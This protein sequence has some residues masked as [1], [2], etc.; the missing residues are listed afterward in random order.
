MNVSERSCSESAFWERHTAKKRFALHHWICLIL[1]LQLQLFRISYALEFVSHHP[2]EWGFAVFADSSSSQTRFTCRQIIY[3]W[4][5]VALSQR[6]RQK[7]TRV[8]VSNGTPLIAGSAH[9]VDTQNSQNAHCCWAAFALMLPGALTMYALPIFLCL[10]IPTHIFAR[11]EEIKSFACRCPRPR[12]SSEKA[13]NN[14]C[15]R[16]NQRIPSFQP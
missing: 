14:G 5:D 8:T 16:L 1:K 4:C 12:S 15:C 7:G 11:E 6:R 9:F 10:L 13:S 3:Q 2:D